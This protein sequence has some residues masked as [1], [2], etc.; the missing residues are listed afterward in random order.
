MDHSIEKVAEAQSVDISALRKAHAEAGR[1]LEDFRSA[2]RLA[3][4]VAEY[5]G[6]DVVLCGSFARREI[7]SESDCDYL[8]MVDHTAD[9]RSI[10]RFIAAVE[11]HMQ[12]RDFHPPGQQGTFGDFVA[13]TEL[14]GRIGLEADSNNTT[15]RRLLFLTESVSVYQPSIRDALLTG[16][17]ERYCV[18]YHPDYRPSNDQVRVPRFLS[19]D[20]VR[21]WR[22]M[23]VDFGAK[24]W[25]SITSDWYLRLAKLL[26]TRKILFAGSL[27]TLFLVD[28]Y[29]RQKSP[30]QTMY[31]SLLEYLRG[32]FDRPPLARLLSC[33]DLVQVESQ[34]A[35]G[36]ILLSYNRFI[37]TLDRRGAR[38]LFGRAL[39][40]SSLSASSLLREIDEISVSIQEGLKQVFFR[41]PLFQQLT[42]EYGLF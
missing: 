4:K 8:V 19:N 28:P 22:T 23:A 29:L 34:S 17:L 33:Y 42:E 30:G 35:L 31:D 25:R 2:L 6:I 12:E 7:T 21:F 1:Q 39:D 9:H 20:L 11:H 32:E 13:A 18:D 16:V 36:N 26:T 14:L 3:L 41:E 40:D 10:V 5:P 24:R 15:T 37:D 38:R 27:M